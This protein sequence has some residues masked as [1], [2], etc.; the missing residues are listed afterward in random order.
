ME[1]PEM[2]RGRVC[3]RLLDDTFGGGGGGGGG[4]DCLCSGPEVPVDRVIGGS[5]LIDGT[6]SVERLGGE[7]PEQDTR[8]RGSMITV[9]NS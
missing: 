4:G 5:V 3:S 9:V 1:T 8:A 2:W 6:A 7:E